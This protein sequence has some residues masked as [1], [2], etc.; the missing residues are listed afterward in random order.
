MVGVINISSSSRVLDLMEFA[1]KYPR[2]GIS[3]KNGT[4]SAPEL[5][6]IR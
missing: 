1:K 5:V 3:D 4:L 6:Y 2:I